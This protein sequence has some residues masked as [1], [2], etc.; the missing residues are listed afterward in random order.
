MISITEEEF[1]RLNRADQR[2]DNLHR[3]LEDGKNNINLVF[4][5]QDRVRKLNWNGGKDYHTELKS[6][7]DRL[8]AIAKAWIELQEWLL[9]P[10]IEPD[11]YESVEQMGVLERKYKLF[12]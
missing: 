4:E 12:E 1:Q 6:E 2:W 3:D 9:A 10:D 5:K 8:K 7:W 11:W